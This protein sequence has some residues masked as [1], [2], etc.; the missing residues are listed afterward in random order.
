ML[1]TVLMTATEEAGAEA[2]RE[3]PF[4]AEWFGIIAL[5]IFAGLFAFTWAFRSVAS[6]H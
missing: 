6:K 3:L 5:A 2:T 4:A 1:T